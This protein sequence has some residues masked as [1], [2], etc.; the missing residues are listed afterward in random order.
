MNPAVAFL[1]E[2]FD[3]PMG[4]EVPVEAAT[5]A[6][7]IAVDAPQI[8][9]I[10]PA[11]QGRDTLAFCLASVREALRGWSHE[12]IVVESSGDG[13]AELVRRC[14][15]EALVIEPPHRLSAG[16]ARNEA[17]KMA[18][19]RWLFCVDQDC[20]VPPEWVD[21]LARH[22]AEPG[23]GAAGGSLGVS[24]PENLSGWAV[25]FLEFL[26]HF[27]SQGYPRRTNSFLIG[28]NSAWVADLF[29]ELA[30]PDQTL[31]EDVLLTH[32]VRQRG[33]AVVYDPSVTVR[34]RNRQ[35]WGEFLR[36]CRAMGRA[37]AHYQ[38]Q[39]HPRWMWWMVHVPLGVF[40][41][42]L[43]VL[44][45]IGLRLLRAP[46]GYLPRFLLLLPVCVLG[47]MVWAVAFRKQLLAIVSQ[48][49][50]ETPDL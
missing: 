49:A 28:C 50:E 13:G 2:R 14:C 24:N 41:V 27:P 42:P 36:Y 38:L 1:T 39:L 8:S 11:Y 6:A 40:A 26:H 10:V 17:A 16:Q 4:R 21:R 48:A 12:I 37:S 31:G 35:G 20:Q 29:G 46:A 32:A 44:P 22:L 30:F 15:P 3:A 9:V 45:G 7:G 19:G 25:Y 43:V 23:V 34:H 33:Y 18:R 47:Q 5:V